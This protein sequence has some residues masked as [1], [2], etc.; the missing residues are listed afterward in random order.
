MSSHGFQ[1]DQNS[2]RK[3]LNL[4]FVGFEECCRSRWITP[5]EICRTL[6]ILLKP[7]SIIVLLFFQNNSKFKNKLKDANLGRCKFISIRHLSWEV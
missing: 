5:S 2:M 6:H 3:F 4:A 7:N 1:R